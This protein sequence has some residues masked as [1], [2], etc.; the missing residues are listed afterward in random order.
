MCKHL[1]GRVL[2]TTAPLLF[3]PD[4]FL[5]EK[6]WLVFFSFSC[7]KH[8]PV[9]T[10]FLRCLCLVKWYTGSL[11]C[12]LLSTPF[13]RTKCLLLVRNVWLPILA[14]LNHGKSYCCRWFRIYVIQGSSSHRLPS[15]SCGHTRS[16]CPSKITVERAKQ[17][18]SCEFW[19]HE[20]GFSWLKL[21]MHA[22]VL[23][24]EAQLG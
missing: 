24:F 5:C 8:H 17:A 14:H 15:H 19:M 11:F 7:S 18:R 2:F 13:L 10:V 20:T 16:F 1:P 22:S 23:H 4:L 3:T 12:V 9:R 21:H 6:V